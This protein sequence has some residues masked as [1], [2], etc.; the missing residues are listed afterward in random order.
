MAALCV[1]ASGLFCAAPAD[2]ILGAALTAALAGA[3]LGGLAGPRLLGEDVRD[4]VPPAG[5]PGLPG[6]LRDPGKRE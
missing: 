1:S 4:G 6:E 5:N 2:R 3:F